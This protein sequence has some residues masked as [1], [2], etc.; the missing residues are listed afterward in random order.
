MMII[1]R[2]RNLIKGV[3][4][5]PVWSKYILSL[6]LFVVKNE[7]EFK[8]NSDTHQMNTGQKC[9]F[10]QPSS[11]L[12]LYEKEVNLVGIKLFNCLP[13]RV[14][15]VNVNTKQF[16]SPLKNYLYLHFFCFVDQ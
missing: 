10:Q 14:K 12:S 3:T 7:N 2:C 15:I 8:L 1:P 11:N 16:K 6:L 13:Q 4:I 5:L 9:D